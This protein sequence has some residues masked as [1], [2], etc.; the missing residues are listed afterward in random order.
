ME[1]ASS[2]SLELIAP[3]LPTRSALA[4]MSIHFRQVQISLKSMFSTVTALDILIL[5]P[6]SKLYSL[7]SASRMLPGN[8]TLRVL[9]HF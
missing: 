1:R 3:T 9:C 4:S 7:V 6:G 5:Q 8:F 2:N